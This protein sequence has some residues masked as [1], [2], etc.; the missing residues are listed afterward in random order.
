VVRGGYFGVS[1][2]APDGGCSGGFHFTEEESLVKHISV[3]C[4]VSVD[5]N[6]RFVYFDRPSLEPLLSQEHLRL[7]HMITGAVLLLVALM[8][9]LSADFAKQLWLLVQ[10]LEVHALVWFDPSALPCAALAALLEAYTKD[11]EL[12]VAVAKL[13]KGSGAMTEAKVDQDGIVWK[14]IFSQFRSCTFGD[15]NGKVFELLQMCAI[16]NGNLTR[17][18]Q[19]LHDRSGPSRGG[20]VNEGAAAVLATMCANSTSITNAKTSS[21]IVALFGLEPLRAMLLLCVATEFRA[22]GRQKLATSGLEFTLLVRP[23]MLPGVLQ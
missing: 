16:C 4:W 9:S 6:Y 23:S 15:E 11:T 19:S 13:G 10:R 3:P 20:D 2:D 17:A 18:F 5:P 12:M 14:F 21:R 8:S 22:V 1:C 7:G